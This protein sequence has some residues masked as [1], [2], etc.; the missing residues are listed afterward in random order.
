MNT[1]FLSNL[2]TRPTTRKEFIILGGV[3]LL[4]VTGISTILKNLSNP[5]LLE[6]YKK[7]DM[8]YGSKGYGV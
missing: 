8:G 6:H 4:S 7:V 5:S 2:L 3:L 1:N